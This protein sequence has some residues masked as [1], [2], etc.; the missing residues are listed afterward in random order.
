MPTIS[1]D[2]FSRRV[3]SLVLNQTLL[4]K[5]RTDLHLLFPL[6]YL[7]NQRKR[8]SPAPIH[9]PFWMV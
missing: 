1:Q 9:L 6:L 5:K 4:P 2:E 8:S 7:S 3:L